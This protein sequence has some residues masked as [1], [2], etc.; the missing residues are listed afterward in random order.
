MMMRCM[1]YVC[2]SGLHEQCHQQLVQHL[3]G[4]QGGVYV[5]CTVQH[6]VH[7]CAFWRRYIPH[8]TY[9]LTYWPVCCT[10]AWNTLAWWY[11]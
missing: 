9:V 2:L 3:G 8:S 1:A 7:A 6:A 11:L 10:S 5:C 4:V